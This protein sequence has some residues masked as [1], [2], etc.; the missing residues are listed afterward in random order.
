MHAQY[1]IAIIGGTGKSG[2]YLVKQLIAQGFSFK[3]LL[4]N[5]DKFPIQHKQVEVIKG[6]VTD[7]HAVHTLIEGCTAVISTLGLG[8]P[9]SEPTIFSQSTMHVIK[10]MNVCGISRY[11]VTTGLNVD[12]PFDR[13]GAQTTMATEWMKNTYPVSTANKQQEYELLVN[14]NIDW[15]LVRL[16]LIEQTDE[17]HTILVNETDCPG[18]TISSTSLAY[19]LIEQ[20]S[21]EI[22]LRKSPFIA[23]G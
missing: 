23:N 2:Q 7:E 18:T 15:T 12:T 10:A 9:A 20:L 1:P 8:K 17:L 4:R 16:P 13:K 21:A 3:L 6:N 14:S 11:I 5:P 19:F 22:W